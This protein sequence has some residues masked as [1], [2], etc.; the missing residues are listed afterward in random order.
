MKNKIK[1]VAASLFILAT[2]V[3]CTNSFDEINTDPDAY[4]TVPYTNILGNVLRR[5]ADQFSALDIAQWAGYLSEVQYLNDYSGYIPTNNTYGNRWSH[6][7]WGH[8]QLQDIL[9]RTTGAEEGN[10]NIRNVSLTMQNYLMFMCVDCFGDIPYSQAFKGAPEDGSVLQTPYDKQSDIYPQILANLKTVADS[11]ATGLGPDDLGKGD[12]LFDGDAAMW[13]K[14]C[15]SLR[16]RIAMR[17]SAVYPSS[18]SIIEEILNNP[19]KYPYI[20]ENKDNAFFWWQ[21]SSP[22]YEPWYNNSLN[23]DDDGMADIFIDHLK[24][25]SDPRLAV[26]AKPAKTDSQYRGYENGAKNDPADRG[27]ISRIGAKFRDDPKGFTP[28]YKACESYFMIAEAALKGWKTP[29]TAQ[30]AYEKAVRLSMEENGLTTANA[31]TYLAGAGKWDGTIARIYM[32]EW[33]ALFKENIE[34]WSLYRR[35]GYPTYIHT[36]KAADGVSPKYPGARSS[37]NGIHNDVP[38]RFSYPDNQYQYNKENVTAAA[39]NVKDYVWGEQLWWDKRT[40]VK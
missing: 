40:G 19:T 27:A 29:M 13:Q 16:L 11:W 10:K 21:G 37:F 4:S 25:M 17:I 12:F 30:A 6:C 1:T 18:Q 32:E 28:F 20:T 33:V 36:S 23:R 31:D 24:M 39:V 22:Y 2:A 8:V 38:F 15:N 5:S 14:F 3:S 9:D 26:Y 7:Y 34:A 35:T